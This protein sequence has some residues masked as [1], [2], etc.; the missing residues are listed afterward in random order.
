MIETLR[1]K[2]KR[3]IFFIIMLIIIFIVSIIKIRMLNEDNRIAHIE[4]NNYKGQ[5]VDNISNGG[6][7]YYVTTEQ[8][9]NDGKEYISLNE[10]NNKAFNTGDKLLFERGKTYYLCLKPNV[11]DSNEGMFYIGS[12]GDTNKELPVIS[13]ATIIPKDTI[14][15]EE[16]G[17]YS[18]SNAKLKDFDGFKNVDNNIGFF[19]DEN[20]NFYGNRKESLNDLK[21][22]Y[23]FYCDTEKLYIKDDTS[24]S[25][26]LGDLYI[27]NSTNLLMLTSNTII[28]GIKFESC[29]SNCIV[30]K[31]NTIKNIIIN[32]CIIDGVGGKYQY[33]LESN[34]KT[35]FGNAI[36][37]WDGAS[38]I[39]LTNNIIKNVYDAG[40]TLQGYN[41]N[42]NNVKIKGN[43]IINTSYPFELFAINNAGAMKE[44][45]ILENLVI[46][47]GKGW[48]ST[49]KPE[50]DVSANFVF[51][52]FKIPKDIDIKI[53]NNYFIDSSR[54]YFDYNNSVLKEVKQKIIADNNY[55]FYNNDTKIINDK[56]NIMSI[57][58]LGIDTT[59]EFNLIED[60]DYEYINSKV[61]ESDNF[62]EV[63]NYYGKINQYYIDK[64]SVK[65]IIAR[66]DVVQEK[67][68]SVFKNENV[69]EKLTS[70]YTSMKKLYTENLE[71]GIDV[72]LINDVYNQQFELIKCIVVEYNKKDFIIT[73]TD[74]NDILNIL[75]NISNE[76]KPLYELYVLED[77]ISKKEIKDKLN[78]II[79]NYNNNCDIDL[80]NESELIKNIKNIY[81]EKIDTMNKADNYLNK[82][83][84]VKTLELVEIMLNNDIKLQANID[85]S[86]IKFITKI[87]TN[88]NV[89]VTINKPNDKVKVISDN[90]QETLSLENND[91]K[92]IKLNIRGY[93]YCYVINKKDIEKIAP[94]INSK[95]GKFVKVDVAGE[96]IK[97]IKIEK[98]G[99]EKIANNG[100]IIKTNGVYKIIATDS[101]GNI[102]EDK[103]IV[104]GILQNKP[105]NEKYVTIKWKT[106]INYF[107][108]LTG[109]KVISKNGKNSYISTGNTFTN[110]NENFIVVV[111]GDLNGS[112]EIDVSN[113]I[114]LR[115]RI[116]NL[117][118][119]T[120]YQELAADTDQNGK[121][122]VKDLVNER[123]IIVGME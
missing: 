5:Y 78:N 91:T 21:K 116:A 92:T 38:N 45:N 98:D 24:P 61:M 46:R 22:Q 121:I 9:Q 10:V 15:D 44:V 50:N 74:Y 3:Y 89:I 40:I 107:Q 17:I 104:Y 76:Y 18:I 69:R 117:T 27:A 51:W 80:S 99:K 37:F 2:L 105:K 43:I 119:F 34:N 108:K 16:N 41:N 29:G 71:S 35:R 57:T 48:A 72:S 97:E 1:Y 14:W 56:N 88:K 82:L 59:S 26:D 95:S 58:D 84:I 54:L 62:E 60:D 102:S 94:K 111:P 81:E 8:K 87:D 93:E 32:K 23:D 13:G 122:D 42:W 114:K 11:I 4:K 86:N 67:Y 25:K 120:E 75:L 77:S 123:K 115:K 118:T 63:F 90:G 73:D 85:Y 52:G 7:T 68:N 19:K 79:S 100:D 83:R 96:N 20:G 66:N 112:G 31:Q 33:G 6:I 110:E 36:E 113:V 64:N 39:I 65:N 101:E 47:Q 28:E 103:L 49:S 106:N 12:Y 109:I 30:K 55:Y 53:K 70:L